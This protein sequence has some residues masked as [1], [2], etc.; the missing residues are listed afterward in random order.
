MSPFIPVIVAVGGLAALWMALRRPLWLFYFLIFVL[1][2]P[3]RYLSLSS[4]SLGS[5]SI[6]GY[7]IFLPLIYFAA[8]KHRKRA[9]KDCVPIFM[10]LFF[11]MTVVSLLNGLKNG[12]GAGAFNYFRPYASMW[13]AVAIPLFF[14]SADEMDG[15]LR[16]FTIWATIFIIVEMVSLQTG[17]GYSFVY[18]PSR[19]SYSSLLSDT[20]CSNMAFIFIY[21]FSMFDLGMKHA[22]LYLILIGFSFICTVMSSARAVWLGML[23]SIAGFFALGRVRSKVYL[24][25][26]SILGI[27]ALFFLGSLYIARYD[28]TLAERLPTLI[29]TQEGTGHWRIMAWHQTLEDIKAHPLIG[30]PMGNEPLFYVESSGIFCTN[31]THNEFLKIARY[32]GLTGLFFFVCLMIQTLIDGFKYIVTNSGEDQRKM[33]ALFLCVV[34]ILVTSTFSQRITSIDICPFIWAI[35]GMVYLKLIE[36]KERKGGIVQ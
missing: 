6:K 25:F 15:L 22:T 27:I 7:E 16:F 24:T 1:L 14:K 28:M 10:V 3:S 13:I 2:E 20:S 35:F 29:N 5:F 21:L 36:E 32:T 34:F 11:L 33:L 4:I 23:V 12:Y 17:I 30:W 9:L 26:F 18:S 8:Y 31:A 19:A